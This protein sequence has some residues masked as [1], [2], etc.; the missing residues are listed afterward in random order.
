MRIKIVGY[1]NETKKKE[2][3]FCATQSQIIFIFTM[4]KLYERNYFCTITIAVYN[5]N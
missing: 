1:G 3:S 4:K 2:T 5:Y